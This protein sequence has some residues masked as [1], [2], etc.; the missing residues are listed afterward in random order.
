[1]FGLRQLF[2][3][4]KSLF[5]LRR[6]H[7]LRGH[8]QP[9]KSRR[10]DKALRRIFLYHAAPF[11]PVKNLHNQEGDSPVPLDTP[12]DSL[13]GMPKEYAFLLIGLMIGCLIGLMAGRF[14]RSQSDNA[15]LT[16]GEANPAAAP[17]TGQTQIASPPGVS[18]VVNGQNID[19]PAEAM[20]EI[21][22]L[23]RAKRKIDAI[24][25]LREATGLGLAE[26]RAVMESLE[27]VIR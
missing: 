19:I 7:Q 9:L 24:K 8:L 5:F 14:W 23:A 20:A 21:Q 26:A 27:K 4:R 18:L 16:G 25:A 12:P 17:A 15:G 13:F 22:S 6:I 11:N 3:L 10:H 1:M 2:S